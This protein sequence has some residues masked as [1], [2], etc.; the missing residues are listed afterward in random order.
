MRATARVVGTDLPLVANAFRRLWLYGFGSRGHIATSIG[1][2]PR[3]RQP[4]CYKIM[5]RADRFREAAFAVRYVAALSATDPIASAPG[6]RSRGPLDTRYW[7]S[8]R[9]LR[10]SA[11]LE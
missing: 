7:W 10:K 5:T 6:A 4:A 2:S 1:G 9:P 8:S 11:P 3:P